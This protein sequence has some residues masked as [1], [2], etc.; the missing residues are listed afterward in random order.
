MVSD[1]HLKWFYIIVVKKK[2]TQKRTVNSWHNFGAELCRSLS[3]HP[4]SVCFGLSFS[5][6]FAINGNHHINFFLF[7]QQ[8]RNPRFC[9]HLRPNLTNMWSIIMWCYHFYST[10]KCALSVDFDYYFEQYNCCLP[11]RIGTVLN[12]SGPNHSN[13]YKFLWNTFQ[14]QLFFLQPP[15]IRSL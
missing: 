15:H 2:Y 11:A 10:L 13:L 9:D 14:N 8:D 3:S 6:P 1:K 4:F 5:F 12:I 7:I